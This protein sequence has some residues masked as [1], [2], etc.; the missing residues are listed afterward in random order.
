[1]AERTMTKG[2][3]TEGTTRA[4]AARRSPVPRPADA[5]RDGNTGAVET[6]GCSGSGGSTLGRSFPGERPPVEAAPPGTLAVA[7]AVG[8]GD[9]AQPAALDER[10]QL[11]GEHPDLWIEFL[12]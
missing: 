12:R 7:G 11:A 4:T 9:D 5:A 3:T 6:N 10:T 1:M 8:D 2:T